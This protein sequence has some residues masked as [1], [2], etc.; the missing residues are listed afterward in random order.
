M[1]TFANYHFGGDQLS[2]LGVKH[3]CTQIPISNHSVTLIAP[4]I[5]LIGRHMACFQICLDTCILEV[6]GYS[7]ILSFMFI[8]RSV[9]VCKYVKVKLCCVDVFFS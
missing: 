1:Y 9:E 8:L 4:V 2:N 3:S 5:R 6:W 7:H